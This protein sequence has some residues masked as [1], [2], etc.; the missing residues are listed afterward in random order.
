MKGGLFNRLVALT[1]GVSLF[2]GAA[3]AGFYLL[4]NHMVH[5]V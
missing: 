4:G 5:A 1:G 2:H 3:V